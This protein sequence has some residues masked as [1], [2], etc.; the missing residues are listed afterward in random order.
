MVALSAARLCEWAVFVA[1]DCEGLPR[2]NDFVMNLWRWIRRNFRTISDFRKRHLKALVC[3]VP[4]GSEAVRDGRAGSK[5]GLT[6]A[7]DGTKIKQNASKHKAM[8]Y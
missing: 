4:A 6:W 2:R 1:A 5:L 8:S 7:L 3:A